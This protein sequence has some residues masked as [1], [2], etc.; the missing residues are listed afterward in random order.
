ML[1][2]LAF[3]PGGFNGKVPI[4]WGIKDGKKAYACRHIVGSGEKK[5]PFPPLNLS[6]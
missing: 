5:K 3:L 1:L 6:G 2:K 4:N